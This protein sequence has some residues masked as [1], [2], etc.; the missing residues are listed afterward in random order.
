[1]RDY[2][3]FGLTSKH[4]N[5]IPLSDIWGSILDKTNVF[6]FTFITV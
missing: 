6:Q 2:Q 5:T 3:H 4:S 1:M